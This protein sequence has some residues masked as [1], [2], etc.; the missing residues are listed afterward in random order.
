MFRPLLSSLDTL[1]STFYLSLLSYAA[2][3]VLWRRCIG[4]SMVCIV[5]TI[6]S[7][8]QRPV[9]RRSRTHEALVLTVNR[10]MQ[11]LIITGTPESDITLSADLNS[12]QPC[13]SRHEEKTPKLAAGPRYT[14]DFED[15]E[16]MI[17][18]ISLYVSNHVFLPIHI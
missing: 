10:Q 15:L 11:S 16:R 6:R 13:S 18:V 2:W 5:R 12:L 8:Y 14:F 1:P 4:R 7:R 3:N 17:R 9:P